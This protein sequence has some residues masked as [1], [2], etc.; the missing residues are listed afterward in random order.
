MKQ[1]SLQPQRDFLAAIVAIL[2]L[3]LALS[4]K[5][6]KDNKQTKEELQ[7]Y[8][9][10]QPIVDESKLLSQQDSILDDNG[11][12]HLLLAEIELSKE[13]FKVEKE[14]EIAVLKLKLKQVKQFT[15][16]VTETVIQKEVVW[17]TVF[18][19]QGIKTQYKYEDPY[20]SIS[21]D[22][23]LTVSLRDTLR[24]TQY[25]K[26]RNIFSPKVYYT[27]IFNTNPYTHVRLSY[28]LVQ[29][30]KQHKILI[31]PSIGLGYNLLKGTLVP[32]I[33]ISLMYNPITIKL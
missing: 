28:T 8:F 12:L 16:V 11:R 5:S 7:Q 31:G 15:K 18:T 19:Y 17:D 25:W 30:V 1:I 14:R 13:N 26:R 9:K 21:L 22:D 10:N 24:H 33:G 32:Q 2:L 20:L 23:T 4:V 3:V 6:C 29:Q 27:D